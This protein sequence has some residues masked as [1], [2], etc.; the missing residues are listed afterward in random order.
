MKQFS[1]I[2]SEPESPYLRL[3][4][5]WVED[6]F[7]QTS[8]PAS[9]EQTQKFPLEIPLWRGSERSIMMFII[10]HDVNTSNKKKQ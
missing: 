2:T 5:L 7:S 9:Q 1:L 4:Y 6:D 8:I 3:N 10:I